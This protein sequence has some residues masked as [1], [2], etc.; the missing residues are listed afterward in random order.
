[1]LKKVG[2]EKMKVGGEIIS[3][4]SF[5]GGIATAN[6]MSITASSFRIYSKK[7]RKIMYVWWGNEG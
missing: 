5:A 1:M 6:R 3:D 2:G 7:S 4:Y